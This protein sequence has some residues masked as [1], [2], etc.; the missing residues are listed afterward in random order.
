MANN[1]NQHILTNNAKV[2]QVELDYFSPTAVF[3]L[4][5]KPVGISHAFLSKVDPWPDDTT[6]P[7]PTEDQK[8]INSVFKNIFFV[9]QITSADTIPVIQ[10]NDWSANTV[11]NYYQYDVDMFQTDTDGLLVLNFYVRNTYDQVFKCLW[12]ANGALSTVMPFFQPGNY[13]TNN[14]FQGSDNYKWK[15]MFT[16]NAGNKVKFMDSNW[17][18][19]SVGQYAPNPLQKNPGTGNFIG[20]GAVEVINVLNGG[21]GYTSTNTTVTITGDGTGANA[22]AVINSGVLTDVQVKNTGQNYTYFNVTVNGTG[23]GAVVTNDVSPIGGHA[24]DSISELGCSKIM[25]SVQ[26]N[27]NEGNILPTDIKYRQ[28]GLLVNP[29]ANSTTPDPANGTSY[30]TTTQMTVA[31]GIGAYNTSEIAYQG[32][33][34]ETATF[35]AIVVSFNTSTNVVQ[36]VNLSGTP[37]LNA[38][39]YGN[40]SKNART[41]LGI[42]EPDFVLFSGYMSY[43]ENRVP[44]QR[45]A[46][47][48]EQ[49]KFVLSY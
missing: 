34:L 14:I 33:S 29:V 15:Y 39:L 22:I 27:G 28:V 2:V 5:G 45:S 18:P 41:L 25:Y 31:P 21:S 30:N 36:L 35:T 43:I 16:I 42:S 9:K 44:V 20:K 7:T 6:P 26:F 48:I 8:Y 32:A 38:S 49:F 13:G 23:T 40:T 11:Y 12:N 4:T 1:P 37:V 47:G 19:V 10:R 3:S 24:F 17:I 46:D